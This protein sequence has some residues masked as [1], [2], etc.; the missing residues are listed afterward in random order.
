MHRRLLVLALPAL[1]LLG[2]AAGCQSTPYDVWGDEYARLRR[3]SLRAQSVLAAHGFVP[4]GPAQATADATVGPPVALR[5]IY[6]Y[7]PTASGEP[8]LNVTTRRNLTLHLDC[9]GLPRAKWPPEV[10]AAMR[11]LTRE[12]SRQGFVFR[13]PR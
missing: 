11:A 1:L 2:A 4:D 5:E 10:E 3:A 12:L 6:R 13:E 8:R 7:Q 9:R